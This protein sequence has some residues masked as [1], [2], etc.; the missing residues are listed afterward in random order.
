M[1]AHGVAAETRS[2]IVQRPLLVGEGPHAER[3]PDREEG[4]VGSRDAI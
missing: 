2:D 4:V 1:A 3:L